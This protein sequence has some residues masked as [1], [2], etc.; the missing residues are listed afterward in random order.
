MQ[1]DNIDV[2]IEHLLLNSLWPNDAWS[3]QAITWNNVDLSSVRASDIHIRA[4]SQ[5][6]PQPSVTKMSLEFAYL[7]FHSNF[8]GVN[9]LKY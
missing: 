8:P 4:I 9:D 6:I 3:N 5:K 2:Y 7:T 1:F